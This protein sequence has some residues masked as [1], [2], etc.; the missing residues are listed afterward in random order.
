MQPTRLSEVDSRV[1]R[2]L[3]E[4]TVCPGDSAQPGGPCG[5]LSAHTQSWE[6]KHSTQKA[7]E[8]VPGLCCESPAGNSHEERGR[9]SRRGSRALGTA[10]LG[11]SYTAW[12]Q[13]LGVSELQGAEHREGRR[14]PV[15]GQGPGRAATCCDEGPSHRQPG[16]L[17]IPPD[18]KSYE[19]LP[20][21]CCGRRA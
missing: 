18:A 21:L 16:P 5:L 13:L 7:E 10:G 9:A 3:V 11:S 12:S 14:H 17:G 19:P 4:E 6:P 15:S 2:E 20:L 8:S 1:C